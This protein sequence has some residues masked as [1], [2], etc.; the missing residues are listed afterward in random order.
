MLVEC[1]MACS[2]SWTGGVSKGEMEI[3]YKEST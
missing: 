2:S 1:E 3:I